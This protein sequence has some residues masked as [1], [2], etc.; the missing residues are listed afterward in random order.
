VDVRTDQW[1]QFIAPATMPIK[2]YYAGGDEDEFSEF[3]H[4]VPSSLVLHPGETQ[5]TDLEVTAYDDS[6]VAHTFIRTLDFA[7]PS[8]AIG[9]VSESVIEGTVWA[10]TNGTS[11]SVTA[12]GVDTT[13]TVTAF[14]KST[15]DLQDL[16]QLAVSITEFPFF[17]LP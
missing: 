15:D 3:F 17:D 6:G 5:T 10:R 2:I 14:S 12:I 11:L 4:F 1:D 16:C 7:Y 13:S 9:E 8:F